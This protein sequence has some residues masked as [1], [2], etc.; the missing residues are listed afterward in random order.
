MKK[1]KMSK[2]ELKVWLEIQ[3]IEVKKS[4][5]HED[6]MFTSFTMP[7]E[8]K[9]KLDRLS[10]KYGMSRSEFVRTMLDSVKE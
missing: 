3:G 8:Y 5:H 7:Y 9:A 2:G 6:Y 10:K 4:Y 1:Q